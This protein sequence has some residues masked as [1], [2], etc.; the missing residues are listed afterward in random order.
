[1][2]FIGDIELLLW[3]HDTAEVGLYLTLWC[4]H[5]GINKKT[6]VRGISNMLLF[7]RKLIQLLHFE[8]K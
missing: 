7:F 6:G 8:K 1:M 2:I 5:A 3:N 4:G